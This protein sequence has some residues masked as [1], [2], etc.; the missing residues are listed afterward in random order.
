VPPPWLRQTATLSESMPRCSM[1]VW[2]QLL[3]GKEIYVAERTGWTHME[4]GTSIRDGGTVNG[5]QRVLALLGRQKMRQI[6]KMIRMVCEARA[7]TGIRIE[8]GSGIVVCSPPPGIPG[9]E[10]RDTSRSWQN[11]A[12]TNLTAPDALLSP[13]PHPETSV[14]QACPSCARLAQS[15]TG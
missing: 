7:H 9:L 13:A 12:L 11:S 3:S 15:C 1:S 14:Q 10:S 5:I 4:T 6:P 8:I 2:S